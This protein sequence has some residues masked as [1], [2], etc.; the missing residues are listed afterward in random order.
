MS[1][2]KVGVLF[3]G[4]SAE[5]EVSLVSAQSVMENLN[6]NKYEIIPIGIDHNGKWITSGEPLQYLKSGRKDKERK[7]LLPSVREKNAESCVSTKTVDVIFPVLHGTYG[8][9]GTVQGFLELA[10]IPYIGCGVAASAIG[11]DKALQKQIFSSHNLP[12]TDYLVFNRRRIL[13]RLDPAVIFEIEKNLGYPC[14]TKPAN[15]GSS[16]G[17]FKAHTRS[18]LKFMLKKT[19]GFDRK[20][21]VE[22]AVP[23]TRE[24]EVAVLGNDDLQVSVCGEIVPSGEFYDYDA[25]Y[26]DGKSKAI[27]PAK[28]SAKVSDKIRDLAREAYLAIDCSGMAR[29]DFL[30]DGKTCEIY[31]SEINTIPGFTSISMYPKL[32]QASGLSYSRLLDKLI[33]LSLERHKDKQ[34]N[35]TAIALKKDWYK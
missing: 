14:F 2:L 20:I 21:I 30:V 22:K 32:W 13:K 28:I 33:Q 3:G 8:E 29:V 12:I 1:K 15:L 23:N 4:K 11:M 18:E 35:E 7:R 24:I 31:L 9:D 27:I 19:A 26:I 34:K 10:N 17:I 16:V 25:K 5:H 6:K